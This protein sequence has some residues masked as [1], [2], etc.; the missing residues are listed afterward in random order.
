[1]A[2]QQMKLKLKAPKGKPLAEYVREDDG[3]V[4]PKTVRASDR[5]WARLEKLAQKHDESVNQIVVLSLR[6]VCDEEG[7]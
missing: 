3:E 5:L 6:K 2:N 1:M 4:L 7:V